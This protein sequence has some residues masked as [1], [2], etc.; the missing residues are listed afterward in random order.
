MQYLNEKMA[1]EQRI[2]DAFYEYQSRGGKDNLRKFKRMCE[3]GMVDLLKYK[4]S[5]RE[6][7]ERRKALF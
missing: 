4:P 2:I 5:T 6:Q 7:T 1:C 3:D